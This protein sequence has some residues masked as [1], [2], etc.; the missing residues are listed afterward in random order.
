M[1][2]GWS[3]KVFWHR[4]SHCLTSNSKGAS[5]SSICTWGEELSQSLAT[6]LS[7]GN[8]SSGVTLIK[9]SDQSISQCSFQ[10]PYCSRSS[11]KV[12]RVIPPSLSVLSVEAFA[13]VLVPVAVGHQAHHDEEE[14]AQHREERHEEDG[15]ATHL[16]FLLIES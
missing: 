15:D 9:L 8:L 5:C 2:A 10:L 13:S 11:G 16:F 7:F 6:V 3:L 14:T 12:Q 1:V 4:S